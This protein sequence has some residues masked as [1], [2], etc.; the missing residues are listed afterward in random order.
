M[1]DYKLKQRNLRASH[2]LGD[3]GSWVSCDVGSRVVWNC[4]VCVYVSVYNIPDGLGKATDSGYRSITE[5]QDLRS[6]SPSG[7][8]P[9]SMTHTNSLYL[10]HVQRGEKCKL[11]KFFPTVTV[12]TSPALRDTNDTFLDSSCYSTPFS[13][14]C[15]PF[16]SALCLSGPEHICW[17]SRVLISTS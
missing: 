15:R 16:A 7:A 1:K 4:V 10:K 17:S 5:T 2:T 8:Y 14:W 13:F 3:V 11:K 9:S 6:S 12:D